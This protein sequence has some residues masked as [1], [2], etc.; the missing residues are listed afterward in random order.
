MLLLD[1]LS[2]APCFTRV[3]RWRFQLLLAVVAGVI[4]EKQGAYG[5]GVRQVVL[6]V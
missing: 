1:V 4:V 2:F 6:V 5:V 3:L